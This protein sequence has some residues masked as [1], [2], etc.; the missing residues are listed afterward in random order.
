MDEALS[1]FD[2]SKVIALGYSDPFVFCKIVLVLSALEFLQKLIVDLN[3]F[4]N[5]C[6]K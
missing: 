1:P 6:R 3:S 5:P 2:I 4:P